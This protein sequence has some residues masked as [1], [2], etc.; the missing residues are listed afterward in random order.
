M[1]KDTSRGTVKIFSK[2][3]GKNNNRPMGSFNNQRRVQTRI[4]SETILDRNKKNDNFSKEFR[5]FYARNKF[6]AGKR[7]YRKSFLSGISDRFLQYIVSCPEEK[8]ENETSDKFKTPKCVSEKGTF[9][10]GHNEQGYKSSETKR[11]GNF[12][13]SE[14]RIFT[15][16]NFSKSS[17]VHEVLCKGSVLSM[18]GN[19]LRP[20]LCTSGLY[21]NSLSNSSF[22]QISKHQNS[23]LSGRLV[24][25]EPRSESINTGSTE[26]PRSSSFIRFYNQQREIKPSTKSSSDIFRGSV[27]SGQ[28]SS[29]PHRRE[30]EQITNINSEYVYKS[31]NSSGFSEN[32]GCNGLLYRTHTKC[33]PVHEANTTSSV[34]FLESCQQRYDSKST[35]YSSSE[36]P[37]F[38]VEKF[39]EH[40]ERPVFA[41]SQ[42][43][44]NNH[45]RC[46][47][48][49]FWGAYGK[50]DFSGF[51]EFRSK[52]L[53][54]KLFGNEG[55]LFDNGTFS[56]SVEEQ[57]CIDSERQYKCS[58]IHKPAGGYKVTQPMLLDLG[59]MALGHTK[60]CQYESSTYSGEKEHISR[61]VESN[62]DTTNRMV[63][64]QVGGQGNFPV[65]G[66]PTD[67]PV[68]FLGESTNRDILHM[69]TS[70]KSISLGCIDDLVGKHVRICFSPDLSNPKD[71]AIYEAVP[72]SDY[73]DSP[74]V[75][76]KTLVHRDST[77]I[78]SMPSQTTSS[79]EFVESGKDTD[80]S[81]Q[82][83]DVKSGCMAS[84]NRCF[85]T[86]GFSEPA[87]KLL[88]A[89]W[90]KGT[91]K[92][93]S[94]KFEK[95]N[96]WCCEKQI[97]PYA[98]TLKQVAD[99]LS[100]LFE[101]GLQ[102]RTIAGYRS[103]LSAVLPP[104]QNTP[105]GQH[106]HIIRLIKG[107][108]NSRPPKVKLLP[109]W[110]LE[111][112][113]KV[114][115][116]APFEPMNEASL[117]FITFKTVFL[118]AVTT[119]RRCSDLQSLR[120]D[121]ESMKMQEKGITFIRHGL[122]KQDRQKHFGVKIFVP[123]FPERKL[124]DP[125]RSLSIYLDKTKS[126]REKLNTSE[127]SKLFLAIKEPH[128]PVSVVTISN[129]IVQTIKEAYSDENMKVNAHS[130]RAVAPSWALFKGASMKSI[131]DSADWALESTFTKFYLRDLNATKMLE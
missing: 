128:K 69:D 29:V 78:D 121:S 107:V 24:D 77:V 75:A 25:C 28:R 52:T 47:K 59:T 37:Y 19:V 30:N 125:K 33:T 15:C 34:E 39:S 36:I 80:L 117:K 9:Q 63:F 79:G 46:F 41:V 71:I 118:I 56:R 22:S 88:T 38:M 6:F 73:F 120:M 32:S 16:T 81:S 119:F 123:S 70:P 89:S 96:S 131:L 103:M 1:S 83:S 12:S 82:P 90:R 14:R 124:V 62:K 93:Y 54:H 74:T 94:A 17:K 98:A 27:S 45:D 11:L 110:D 51:L 102:Y 3:L 109:E 100:F 13:R 112:V 40:A 85:Q 115:E 76:Q 21:K 60:Q 44:C 114:L 99:F 64:E 58:T 108:F 67:R 50:P 127:R 65:V 43:Q 97:N 95:Y 4:H 111:L 105:V 116:N 106:P 68:C 53:A 104:V 49:W 66:S 91:Q 10:N 42:N 26:M 86:E 23:S 113:L 122:S 55:S 31:D 92:D 84:L 126:Y 61:P 129:W 87:R 35:I 101:S 20:N 57:T 18:E 72:V 48:E 2:K 130:T 5:Y 8:R 7:R